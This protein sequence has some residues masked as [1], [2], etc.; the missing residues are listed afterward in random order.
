MEQVCREQNDYFRNSTIS[1]LPVL[2]SVA[3]RK[4]CNCA[5]SVCVRGGLVFWAVP[6]VEKHGDFPQY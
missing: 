6:R 2:S 4:R 3:G 5:S 1:T